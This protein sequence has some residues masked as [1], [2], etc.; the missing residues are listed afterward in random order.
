MQMNPNRKHRVYRSAQ[1]AT[2]NSCRGRSGGLL[3]NL[4]SWR[5]PTN[6]GFPKNRLNRHL[7]FKRP[8]LSKARRVASVE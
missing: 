5:V 3:H 8:S 1:I 6:P 4:V 7:L 2:G